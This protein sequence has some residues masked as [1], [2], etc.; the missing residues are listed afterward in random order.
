M[1]CAQ[2]RDLSYVFQPVIH[3]PLSTPDQQNSLNG[4]TVENGG[5]SHKEAIPTKDSQEFH[6]AMREAFQSKVQH[7]RKAMSLFLKAGKGLVLVGND[8]A[9]LECFESLIS[10]AKEQLN[11]VLTEKSKL[12]SLSPLEKEEICRQKSL[13]REDSLKE[14]AKQD[15]E[16]Q[17]LIT[18]NGEK[19]ELRNGYSETNTCRSQENG[20]VAVISID[21]DPAFN[22]ET[23]GP[24]NGQSVRTSQKEFE[25]SEV[26]QVSDESN[27]C[28]VQEES[29]FFRSVATIVEEHSMA[30]SESSMSDD[31]RFG[32]PVAFEEV[33]VEDWSEGTVSCAAEIAQDDVKMCVVECVEAMQEDFEV[34]TVDSDDSLSVCSVGG[35]ENDVYT[36]NIVVECGKQIVE[37]VLR[38]PQEKALIRRGYVVSE[39]ID[40]EQS[41]VQDL[42]YVVKGYI[43]EFS[44]SNLPVELKNK[45]KE[46]F[47]N[48]QDIHEWH[49]SELCNHLKSCEDEPDK[50]GEVF[51][52]SEQKLEKLYSEYCRNKPKS[53]LL[54]QKYADSFFQSCKERLG[55]RLQLADYLI[56]PVQRI[57]KYQLLLKDILKHTE[58]AGEDCSQLEKALEVALRILKRT[59]DMVNVGMLQGFEVKAEE[60]GD[61]LLQDEFMVVDGKAKTKGK[62]RRVFLFEKIIIFSEP[63]TREGGLPEFR[64]MHS[65]KTKGIGQ[66]ESVDSDPCKW[67]VWLRK[68][69][70][71][72][73]YLLKASSQESKELWIKSIKE[74]H[75]KKKTGLLKAWN[76]YRGRGSECDKDQADST[77]GGLLRIRTQRQGG[78]RRTTFKRKPASKNAGKS[79]KRD[80]DPSTSERLQEN[81]RKFRTEERMLAVDPSSIEDECDGLIQ[82]T[83]LDDSPVPQSPRVEISAE[84]K[85]AE[86]TPAE[87]WL[88]LETEENQLNKL[89]HL[90]RMIAARLFQIRDRER[91]LQLYNDVIATTLCLEE[92]RK[93]EGLFATRD[94]LL[95]KTVDVY[96]AYRKEQINASSDIE[97][98]YNSLTSL[99]N[100]TAGFSS[101]SKGTTWSIVLYSI[102]AAA[103][104]REQH[105]REASQAFYRVS[106]VYSNLQATACAVDSL[107]DAHW[108][109]CQAEDYSTAL[110]FLYNGFIRALAAKDLMRCLRLEQQALHLVD[111]INSLGSKV[112][113]MMDDEDELNTRQQVSTHHVEF[114]VNM[115]RATRRR[116]W[117]W[118]EIAETE[119]QKLFIK[120]IP[121]A[122]ACK[123]N[124]E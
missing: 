92:M 72:E 66:T 78:S 44:S 1:A 100:E 59:N 39:L 30:S 33:V 45:E 115:S 104:S 56:K 51:A 14:K 71:A 11:H 20:H 98:S 61:L 13:K 70:G 63:M 12:P 67:A 87:R 88:K 74:C 57:T 6:A 101:V 49:S 106:M 65:M 102:T 80:R 36:H 55:H 85:L 113:Q 35:S 32:S 99:L 4:E 40:T 112:H 41:Y 3:E 93:L 27:I 94:L 7:P 23:S 9:A 29:M 15:D 82:Q 69:G 24:S 43:P 111:K 107:L 28:V 18:S 116:D 75:N 121:S 77:D 62:E 90:T 119:L 10:L 58:K 117:A 31:V 5:T 86:L 54:V 52:E 118:F 83:S 22:S 95:N 103:A 68:L 123:W 105:W 48:I 2:R 114:L 96:E 76:R 89:L 120:G 91:A 26:V 38:S 122:T 97:D 81:I 109:C 37:E 19:T 8:E 47:S 108:M 110:Q 21:S 25:E 60:T 73:I 79:V 53:D 124:W 34:A 46:I 50:I 64:F 42:G 16:R 17:G 84:P